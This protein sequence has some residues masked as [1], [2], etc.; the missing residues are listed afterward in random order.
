M[1][2][3]TTRTEDRAGRIRFRVEFRRPESLLRELTRCLHRG[4]VLLDALRE[5]EVG[6]RFVFE[7]VAKGIQRPIEV[8]GEVVSRRPGLEGRS[9]LSITY[10]LASRGGLDEAVYRVLDAQRKE[11]KRSAPRMPM[12][13]RA[14]EESPYSP[15]YL[16]LDL[17]LGGAGIEI[18]A[19][20]LPKAISLGAPVLLQFSMRGGAH[21][22]L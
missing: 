2:S 15:G 21:L 18:E 19:T 11:R 6:T 5:V 9:R 16:I 14:T 13:L 22:H 1:S 8:E 7:M 10:R 4:C 3:Q 17:S 12:N 20:A